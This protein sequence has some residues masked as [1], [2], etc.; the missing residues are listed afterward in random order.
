MKHTFTLLFALT[1]L[2]FTAASCSN[3]DNKAPATSPYAGNYQIE[4][5]VADVPVDLDGDGYAQ[6][7]MVAEIHEFFD[8]QPDL[9]LEE[10]ANGYKLLSFYLPHPNLIYP[11]EP[12]FYVAYT[13]SAFGM[14]YKYSE[15]EGLTIV[16][17]DTPEYYQTWG[18]VQSLIATGNN[19]LTCVLVKEY[20]DYQVAALKSL[21]VTITYV[22]A[23]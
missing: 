23:N 6:N 19:R 9:Q 16:K 15:S 22:K 13:R 2:F 20:Y 18:D 4:Q 12:Y 7:N 10:R 21:T 8:V 3:D 1:A 11:G 14:Q 17:E 5:M